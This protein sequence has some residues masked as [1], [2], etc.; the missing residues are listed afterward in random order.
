MSYKDLI[1][2]PRV[3]PQSEPADPRQV[4]NSAGGF[5][6]A[7]DAWGRL[8]RFLVIGSDTPTFYATAKALTCENAKSVD[9]CLTLDVRRALAVISDVSARGRAPS[10][11]AAILATALAIAHPNVATAEA[12]ALVAATCRTGTH[13]FTLIGL[14][15]T[16][17]GW[18]RK[19]RRAVASWYESKDA[20]S[21]TYQ[22]LKYRQRAG[23]SHRDA[24]RMAHPHV[25]D[26][27]ARA[28]LDFVCNRPNAERPALIDT[29]ESL[30]G[31]DA[32]TVAATIAAHGNRLAW[33]MLP[34][35][36]LASPLVWD[37]L[38]SSG[39]PLTALLRNLGRMSANGLLKPMSD[40]ERRA[41]A[42]LTNADAL[43]AARVHPVAILKALKMY[44]AGRGEKGSLA[45]TVAPRI[46]EALNAAFYASFETITP[47]GKRMLLALDVSGSMH[48]AA[49]SG[50]SLLTCAEGAAAMSMATLRVEAEAYTMGFAESFRDLGITRADSLDAARMKAHS[51]TFGRTDCAAP[52]LWALANGIK[53][54]TFVVYTDNE[55]YF[56]TIH[57]HQALRQYRERTGIGAKLVVVGMSSNGFTIADPTDAGML[58]C[59]GFDTS[60]PQ[61]IAAFAQG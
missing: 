5:T 46:V 56:G 16:L 30:K 8:D 39:L 14:V 11:D 18:G 52:M 35:E 27:T 29:V 44:A 58:D 21:L 50:A 31:A 15:D 1:S 55:T 40:A 32:K 26:A 25:T 2:N 53:V 42:A 23:W 45:W 43:R 7:L 13:L 4:A 12:V 24:L 60:T 57:P 33:E 34:S 3:T 22:V 10:N 36:S 19:A 48:G 47:T 17:R 6:F 28:V 41:A 51:H 20:N 37:A 9:E 54:D 49:C 38:L 59:V 61:A